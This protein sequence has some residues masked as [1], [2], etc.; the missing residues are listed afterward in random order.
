MRLAPLTDRVVHLCQ[1]VAAGAALL[2][3]LGACGFAPTGRTVARPPRPR[4]P[5]VTTTIRSLTGTWDA[6][7]RAGGDTIRLSMSLQQSGDAV[8]G[9]LTVAGLDYPTD[10]RV[11]SRIDH[12]GQITLI[13][14]QLPEHIV[15]DGRIDASGD[16]FEASLTG[17]GLPPTRATFIRR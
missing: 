10:S 17:G 15:V 11:W 7:A 5:D 3:V 2:A 4:P 1:A 13:F 8:R 14:G 9:T 6:S 12:R 16:R